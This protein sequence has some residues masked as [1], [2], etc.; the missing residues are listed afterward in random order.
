[1]N[2]GFACIGLS[3]K[4]EGLVLLDCGDGALN[5]LL[6][7][8]ANVNAIS[9]IVI[10]HHHSDHISGIT[11]IIET[12]GIRKRKFDLQVFGPPG[13][14]EY[15]ATVQKITN[16]ASKREF[17]I[18]LTE[19]EPKQTIKFSG[20]SATTFKMEHTVPCIGYRV[21]CPDGKIL[22]YTGDTMLCEALKSLGENADLFVHEATYL[23]KDLELA[24]PPRHSTALQAAIAAKAANARNLIL[25]HVSDDYET[26]ELMLKEAKTEFPE[27]RVASDGLSSEI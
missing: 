27:V 2:R 26:P 14:K 11:Q 21:T 19:V 20:Y 15:F 8:G 7:F 17:K 4:D 9:D 5:K 1:V 13:L 3:E 24:K 23:H 25:T 16:V 22:A 6:K 18:E 10:T 12:M